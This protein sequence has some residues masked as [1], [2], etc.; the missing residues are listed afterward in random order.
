MELVE[1]VPFLDPPKTVLHFKK[2]CSICKP[3]A[4]NLSKIIHRG[5]N[6]HEATFSFN[7]D[8]FRHLV[9]VVGRMILTTDDLHFATV[10]R[11]PQFNL[12]NSL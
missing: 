2:L 6:A 3:K 11:N 10:V 4:K 1:P 8:N 5:V 7:Q 9:R 12:F